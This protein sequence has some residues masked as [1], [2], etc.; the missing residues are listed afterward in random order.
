MATRSVLI[1]DDEP[2][3]RWVLGKAL[4]QAGYTVYTAGSGDEAVATLTRTPVDLVLL[5]LKL[6]GEDGLTVLRRLRGRRPDLVVMLLT[7][8]GT[9]A[10]AVEAM[11]LGAA[12]FLRKPFDVEE[13]TFKVARALERREM[14]QELARLATAQRA[15]PALASFVGASPAWQRVIAQAQLASQS[16]EH[17]LLLGRA[18]SGRATLGRAVHGASARATARFITFDAQLYQ[19]DVRRSALLGSSTG[20]GAWSAAGSGT[21]MIGGLED[22]AV[23]AEALGDVMSE[24]RVG[25]RV[26]VIATDETMFPP[27]LI[28]HIPLRL[29]VPPL[30]E[31]AGDVPL[32]THHFA[33]DVGI[34]PGAM[35]ALEQYHWPEDVA[36]LRAA[37]TS[38]VVLA[39][40]GPIDRE[41][42]PLSVRSRAERVAQ[43]PFQLPA[44]GVS[45]DDVE[46]QLIRQA[47]H[48]A[49][50]NKS[51]AAELLGLTRHTLLYRMEKHG[52]TGL[53]QP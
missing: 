35:E 26:L 5:D 7:A 39:G 28:A 48:Q 2:N 44:Q 11:Q 3:M 50:G 41:H 12:D 6:K 49:R 46:Q 52:I 45:L 25:P 16:D 37:I 8:Y 43:A 53:E 34:T 4:E 21:L 1:V 40:G 38:A 29:V 10:T 30:A 15:A 14:Q 17:A 42:L 18:G 22:D 24:R 20:G 31:R 19:R 9:V 23:L 51:K 47:L 33:A 13:I 27:S 32:L 36:E